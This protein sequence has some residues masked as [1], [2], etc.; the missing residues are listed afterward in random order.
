MREKN[1]DVFELISNSYSVTENAP[2]KIKNLFETYRKATINELWDSPKDII[3][4]YHKT[5]KDV[6]DDASVKTVTFLI[7]NHKKD[8]LVSFFKIDNAEFH[9]EKKIQQKA[10][11]EQDYLINEKLDIT[12]IPIVNKLN[13][14][15][16][17]TY[18]INNS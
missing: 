6:F 17:F 5:N 8:N 9:F 10:F 16:A 1:I 3:D 4:T 7:S 15:D 2:E 18:S 13:Q 14:F 12:A 11:I